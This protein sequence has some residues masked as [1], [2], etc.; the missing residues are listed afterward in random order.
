M[1]E[2]VPELADL[3]GRYRRVDEEQPAA[4]LEDPRRLGHEAV[5]VGKMMRRDPAG[6]DI[7]RAILERKLLGVSL[8]H[9]HVGQSELSKRCLGRCQHPRGEIGGDD[10]TDV[11]REDAGDVAAAGGDVQEPVGRFRLPPARS[12]GVDRRPPDGIC[13]RRNSP[14]WPRTAPSPAAWRRPPLRPFNSRRPGRTCRGTPVE[15]WRPTYNVPPGCRGRHPC[16]WNA[17]SRFA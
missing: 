11:G 5:R 13:W 10:L 9:A 6:D 3:T 12:S 1:L 17:S 14:R 7:E 15:T 4:G 2:A 8:G 16:P